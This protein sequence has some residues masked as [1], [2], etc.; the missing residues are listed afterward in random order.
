[1]SL[2]KRFALIFAA[3][4]IAIV[5]SIQ[6]LYIM[7]KTTGKGKATGRQR[8]LIQKYAKKYLRALAGITAIT[9]PS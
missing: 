2:G 3:F 5:I 6:F 1:M 9:D 8:M 4:F 7:A